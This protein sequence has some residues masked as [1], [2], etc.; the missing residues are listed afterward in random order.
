M[1]RAELLE[2]MRNQKIE[3]K[4]K[5]H[6]RSE[7]I[8]NKMSQKRLPMLKKELRKKSKLLV[9]AEL[10]LPFDPETGSS[11]EWNVDNKWRPP[12][13]A[14]TAALLVKANADANEDLKKLLMKRAGVTEW[15]TSSEEFTKQDWDVFRPY[16]VPR[17]FTVP[18]VHIN[19]PVMTKSS[20]GRDYA[21]SVQRDPET[22]EVIGEE[23]GIFKVNRL[24]QDIAYEEVREYQKRVD[25]K[26]EGFLH[27][28]Q[29]QKE[30]KSQ[31]F[32]KN[33]VSDDKP[34]NWVQIVELPLT[35]K[36]EVS[37]DINVADFTLDDARKQVVISRYSKGIKGGIDKYMDGS[38]EKFDIYFDFF[39]LDMGCP[40]E[41]D[42]QTDLGRQR[43][44]L[45]TTFDK[46]SNDLSDC[47]S[48]L[49][50]V[51]EYLD[52]ENDIEEEVRRSIFISVYSEEVEAQ[53]YA[54][55]KTVLDLKTNKYLT[56]E[57][58]KAHAPTISL[59]FGSEAEE[60]LDEI[61]A[62]VSALP[63][64]E[65]ITGGEAAQEAKA[66]DLNSDDFADNLEVD[67]EELDD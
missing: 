19:I 14:T 65:S 46:P 27:T 5:L 38:W 34:S 20:Y 54:S 42:S 64:G 41:G 31:I 18:V 15:D 40:I 48:V 3:G 60:L 58:I 17:I 37:A 4:S 13:S 52:A 16:R 67:V 23:P 26:E 45:D 50:G 63:E 25:N 56:Q 55:L 12:V 47:Q 28:E 53:M 11:D 9:V 39:E 49:D 24:F 44:G 57:I 21:I 7:S 66:Y 2:M 33:P 36:Y 51:R 32:R 6:M 30:Y 35:S 1:T 62:G 43:I 61:D 59:I 8:Q 29:Q 22:C 10:A